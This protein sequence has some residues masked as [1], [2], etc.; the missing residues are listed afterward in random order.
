VRIEACSRIMTRYRLLISL[1]SQESPHMEEN[2]KNRAS[3]KNLDSTCDDV[4]GEISDGG[5][6]E[7]GRYIEQLPAEE[8]G[9][10]NYCPESQL[11]STQALD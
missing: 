11:K 1:I 2:S 7:G 10:G 8:G 9:K 4:E 5:T 6:Q 3:L